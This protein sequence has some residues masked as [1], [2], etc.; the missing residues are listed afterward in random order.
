[1]KVK[2]IE[3]KVVVGSEE[4][5][6]A[7]REAIRLGINLLDTSPYYGAGMSEILVGQVGELSLGSIS[8]NL[9]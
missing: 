2:Q 3:E 9:A 8:L 1:M 7:I 6:E 5:I 4:C